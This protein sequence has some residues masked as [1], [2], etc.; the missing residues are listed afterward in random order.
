MRLPDDALD[1]YTHNVYLVLLLLFLVQPFAISNCSTPLKVKE[2]DDVVCLCNSKGGNPAPTASWYKNGILVNGAGHSKNLLFLKNMSRSDNATYSCL[3]KS[4]DL[5]DA[6][7]LVI[8]VQC[9]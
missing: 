5:S 3:V 7:Q 6:T 8:Q 4:L 1:L 2:G 9:K